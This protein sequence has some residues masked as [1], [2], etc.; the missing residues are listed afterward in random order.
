LASTD[1]FASGANVRDLYV[2]HAEFEA[3]ALA[4]ALANWRFKNFRKFLWVNAF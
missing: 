1:A 3:N 2:A 4:A